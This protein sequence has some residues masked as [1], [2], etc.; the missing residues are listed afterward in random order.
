MSCK[1]WA[2]GDVRLMVDGGRS[3]VDGGRWSAGD[4]RW[5]MGD[6]R[7]AVA[8]QRPAQ[9]SGGRGSTRPPAA[10]FSEV[11]LQHTH[12]NHSAL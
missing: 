7:Q 11:T 1:R 6:R 3:T 9:T 8:V 12:I 2:V 5:A 4:G 10:G